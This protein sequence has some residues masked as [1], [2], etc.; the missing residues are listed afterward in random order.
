MVMVYAYLQDVPIGEG[1]YRRIA[2]N[3]GPEPIA[4]QL[5]H[6]CIREPGEA[7]E[8]HRGMGVRG[9]LRPGL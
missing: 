2:D 3:L 6:L 5:L 1:L 7:A 9:S 4:G 8:L